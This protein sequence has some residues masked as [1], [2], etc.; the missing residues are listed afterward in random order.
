MV[1]EEI[2]NL[3]RQEMRRCQMDEKGMDEYLQSMNKTPEQFRDELRPVA[4]RSVKQ[5]L[6]LTEVAR[7]EN[8][9]IDESDFKNEI[10]NMIKGITDE[11][12]EQF[13][14]LLSS[15]QSQANIASA[16]ATR[17]TVDRLAEIANRYSRSDERRLNLKLRLK[18]R[19][20]KAL[21]PDRD[22]TT[23]L[24]ILKH[25]KSKPKEVKE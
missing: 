20:G 24:K 6:V 23:R 22:Q 12:K 9:Q 7:T 13:I 16:I 14:Q 1:E 4:M 19:R 21:R 2:D 25:T 18:K 5:S 17:K 10:E 15:P 3:I 11:R 8:I